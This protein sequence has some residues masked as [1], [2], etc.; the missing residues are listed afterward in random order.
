MAITM[1]DSALNRL[2]LLKKKRQTPSAV[3]RLGVRGGG[4]SGL[5][6]YMDLVDG[7]EPK[8]KIFFFGEGHQISVDKKSYLFLNGSEIDFQK[9]MVKTGFVFNNPLASRSCS[10]GESFTL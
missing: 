6:Y 8:D 7:P 2:E 1:T 10:C 4:C 5:S 9:T 3:L